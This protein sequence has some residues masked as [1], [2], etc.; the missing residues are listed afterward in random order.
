M[1]KVSL[2]SQLR[3][4]E[5]DTTTKQLIEAYS[6]EGL[7]EE[8]Y[9]P[10]LFQE[11]QT[12]SQA[13]NSAINDTKIESSLEEKDTIRDEIIRGIGYMLQGFIYN[14][15]K[16]IKESAQLVTTVFDKYGIAMATESYDRESSLINSFLVDVSEPTIAEA[17][18]KLNG[19]SQMVE[20]LTTAQKDFEDAQL[21]QTQAKA[22][23]GK[24]ATTLKKELLT[25]LN[26]KVLPYIMVM[27][28]VDEGKYGSFSSTVSEIVASGNGA[29]KRR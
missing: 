12:L 22:G 15:N 16:S 2:S 9:L 11:V 14:P 18:T 6:K 17:I 28:V 3:I 19:F 29:L 1:K 20:S 25:L 7:A 27:S 13:L 10:T 8:P 26:G 4:T 24:S 21:Q 5:I 23:K